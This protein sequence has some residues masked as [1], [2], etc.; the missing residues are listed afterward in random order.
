MQNSEIIATKVHGWRY[1]EKGWLYKTS[2][3]EG[4]KEIRTRPDL[5]D[6]ENNTDQAIAAL[7]AWMESNIS[8]NWS[9]RDVGLKCKSKSVFLHRG[10]TTLAT[11]SNKSLSAAI[12]EALVQ[13]TKEQLGE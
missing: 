7:E 5:F 9:M 11:A 10:E 2:S 13:A 3:F 8:N 6:P 4:L 1:C 12:V